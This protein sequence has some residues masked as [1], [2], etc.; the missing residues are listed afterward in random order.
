MAP[1]SAEASLQQVEGG[2]GEGTHVVDP[3]A[4]AGLDR[5]RVLAVGA[6]DGD[7]GMTGSVAVAAPGRP[8][9]PGLADR[10]CRAELAADLAGEQQR[11]SLSGGGNAGQFLL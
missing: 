9:G 3:V 4:A 8:G 6:D 2:D 11:I 10:P 5:D 1:R 7:A